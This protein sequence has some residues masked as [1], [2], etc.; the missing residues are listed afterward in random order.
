MRIYFF[1][2]ISFVSVMIAVQAFTPTI[3]SRSLS[4]RAATQHM[5]V[6]M[7]AIATDMT[8]TES[9]NSVTFLE[10][11]SRYSPLT[12]G[13]QSYATATATLPSSSSTSLLSLQEIKKVTQEEIDQKKMTFNLLF[14]GGG[15]V[16]PFVAT[17]FYFGFKFWEK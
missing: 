3:G 1:L 15:F 14:W 16:A 9:M 6:P 11:T 7:P 4:Y 12:E 5:L 2:S 8:I 10:Q 17:V 13:I